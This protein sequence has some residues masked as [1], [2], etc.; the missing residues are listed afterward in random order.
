MGR[1]EVL[2]LYGYQEPRYSGL[3]RQAGRA[4]VVFGVVCGFRAIVIIYSGTIVLS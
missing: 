3:R 4:V 2:R 1:N